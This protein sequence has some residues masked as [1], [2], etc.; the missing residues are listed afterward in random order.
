MP[1][2][3]W[4]WSIR[5]I[6]TKGAKGSR[7][8]WPK[9]FTFL[10]RSCICICTNRRTILFFGINCSM[11]FYLV[12][13]ALFYGWDQLTYSFQ[14]KI[15]GCISIECNLA[16]ALALSRS[17]SHGLVAGL[18]G[19]MFWIIFWKEPWWKPCLKLVLFAIIFFTIDIIQNKL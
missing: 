7:H 18:N 3:M 11:I 9:Y 5:T 2:I 4:S 16:A 17:H 15:S 10:P 14:Q 13:C 12:R 1:Y 8:I 19:S 6:G